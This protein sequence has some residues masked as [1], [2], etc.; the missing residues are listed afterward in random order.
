M[1]PQ[2]EH[3]S[4][5]RLIS[6]FVITFE[7]RQWIAAFFFRACPFLNDR[8]M[9]G[10]FKNADRKRARKAVMNPRTPK[11]AKVELMRQQKVAAVEEAP[12]QVLSRVESLRFAVVGKVTLSDFDVFGRR[13]T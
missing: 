5:G 11:L 13:A 8:A 7:L 3:V 1:N 2:R 9:P 10:V 12:H 6:T 4:N